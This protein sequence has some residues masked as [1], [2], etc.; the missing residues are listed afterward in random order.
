MAKVKQKEKIVKAARENQ[1]NTYKGAPMILSADFLK[2]IFQARS[3]W[4]II[5]IQ[6][7]EKPRPATKTTL[8][9]KAII[10]NEGRNKELSRQEKAK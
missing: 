3:E 1:M 4:N 9:S 7:D 2:E 6:S 5:N 10:Y 8:P